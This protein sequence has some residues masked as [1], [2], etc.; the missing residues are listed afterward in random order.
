MNHANY[1]SSSSNVKC[2]FL[3]DC[4]QKSGKSFAWLYFGYL[5]NENHDILDHEYFYCRVC[6]VEK[7]D[8]KTRYKG[9]TSTSVML[10]HLLNMHN[11]SEENTPRMERVR[12]SLIR[13]T[14]M[15]ILHSK[16]EQYI[17]DWCEKVFD[18]K[19]NL[20]SHMRRK[21]IIPKGPSNFT[22][23]VCG[24]GWKQ[25]CDLNKHMRTHSDVKYSCHR[26]PAKLASLG[27]LTLGIFS[28]FN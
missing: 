17:C 13:I 23:E 6:V 18:R 9:N 27:K 2:E 24:K 5:V 1:P 21:H 19:G 28:E 12:S 4:S 22:C 8:L 14:D 25:N 16:N 15:P 10:K 20:R 7:G 26:C 3:V 11:L